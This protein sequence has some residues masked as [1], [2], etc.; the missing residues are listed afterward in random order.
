MGVLWQHALVMDDLVSVGG[1]GSF[2]QGHAHGGGGGPL[3]APPAAQQLTVGPAE[4]T[5][6]G[7]VED[8]VQH[9]V[10]V[11]QPQHHR[12]DDLRRVGFSP[13]AHAGEVGVVGG[14]ADDKGPQDGRQGNGG[15]VLPGRGG[16]RGRAGEGGRGRAN[17]P[18][19]GKDKMLGVM[20]RSDS[21]MEVSRKYELEQ[22]E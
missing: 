10:E 17:A 4:V 20:L 3:M 2:L 8:G 12:V 21:K 14:P 1:V 13:H 22:A 19:L 6:Q 15:L 9:R 11:A 16:G 5:V 7:R 18:H